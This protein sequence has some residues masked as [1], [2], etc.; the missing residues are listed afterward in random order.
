MNVC[1][2]KRCF[3]IPRIAALLLLASAMIEAQVRTPVQLEMPQSHNPL[4]PYT[5]DHVPEPVLTNSP[6]L[7]RLIRDG[8]LYLSLKDAIDL[9]LENNLDLAIA[10]YNLPIADADL[11]RTRAGGSFLGV[12][13]GVV[14]G[15]PGGGVGGYGAGAPGAGAGGTTGGAGGAGAGASGLVQSTLGG[16]TP[17]SSYDP[18]LTVATGIEHLT[19]PLSSTQIYG[20]PSLQLNT[21]QVNAS[22]TQAFPTGTSISFAFNNNRQ[23]TNSPDFFLSPALN[24][25]YRFT[26][27]Q[28]L[29][30]GFGFGPNLRY[31]HIAKNNKKISDIAFKNQIIATVT[32]VENMYWDLV[33]AYEQARVNEQSLAFANQTLE[34]A[35]KQLQL[36]S[37]PELDVMKAEA[38]VS[39]R[40]QDLTVA[41]T[42][43][44]LQESLMKNALTKS[45][46]D[47]TLG[48]MPVVPTDRMQ[49]TNTEAD[50][51]KPILD[52]IAEGLQNRPELLETD[53]DLAN[54][55][56]SRKAE[57]NAL[58]PTLSL[59]G[60]YGGSGLAGLVPSGVTTTS[61]SPTDL[62]GAWQTAF[63]NSSPDYFVGLNLNIPFRNRVAK[64]DQYRS[65]LEYRQA[66]LRK[67]QL[68]KQIRIEI[69][70]AQYALEQ[71]HA[72]VESARKARDLAERSFE[73]TKKEQDLGSG[74][75]Y[76][77]MTAQRD[78]SVAELDLVTAM[79][80]YQKARVELDRTTGA[81]LE[82][83]GVLIQDAVTGTVAA[84]SP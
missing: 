12:N 26:F 61:T 8:K 37:I 47:P 70:N 71:S 23:T 52:L 36:E 66:S 79:T 9:A 32:Q 17:V 58:L 27:Q 78:L 44:Q 11:F 35:K 4:S 7:D 75:S 83:N 63:N 64:A 19:E 2:R 55:Q 41:R 39:R 48:E 18:A 57:R 54:R 82:H 49:T 67:E 81:T 1:C 3:D 68:K 31:L 40:D 24:T 25:Y 42:S 29:L 60:F 10:R 45:L 13:T 34:N 62:T 56:I 84:S 6:R 15:T 30:A 21:A 53:I 65:E 22:Y 20:V 46:D 76:Q 43:L 28:Q 33:N 5:A 38:E 73:I 77:T 50:T 72:R 80:T 16:G 69:R 14:Q 59:V 51:G 74:S